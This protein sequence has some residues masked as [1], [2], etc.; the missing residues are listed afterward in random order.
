MILINGNMNSY[1]HFDIFLI[2]KGGLMLNYSEIRKFDV[3]NGP[4]VRTTIFVSGCTHKCEGCFNE[5]LQDFNYGNKWTKNEENEFISYVSD[6]VVV[7]VNILGGE[8]LQQNMD[9]CLLDLLKRIKEEYPDK[10][11]W[12]WT[13]YVFEDILDNKEK[14]DIIK[15]VDILVDGKFEIDK[16]NLKLKYRGSENQRVIDVKKSLEQGETFQLNV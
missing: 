12:L 2:V 15:L 13:G 1:C 8:P 16:R 9:S 6:P 7:G 11:I 10:S 5:E 14:M 3:T 4:G